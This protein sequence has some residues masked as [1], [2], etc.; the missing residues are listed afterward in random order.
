M[1]NFISLRSDI[2]VSWYILHKTA[3]RCDPIFSWIQHFD[4]EKV[5]KFIFIKLHF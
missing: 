2:A 5:R 3:R 4:K 1:E